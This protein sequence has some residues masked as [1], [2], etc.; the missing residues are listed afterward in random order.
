MADSSRQMDQ[1]RDSKWK[2][3][4]DRPHRICIS[5]ANLFY[6]VLKSRFCSIG[7]V[8]CVLP[9]ATSRFRE[10]SLLYCSDLMYKGSVQTPL[11]VK[12]DI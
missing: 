9:L 5:A 11:E 8:L 4:A 3:V 6:S 10:L 12:S 1:G 7:L 2:K